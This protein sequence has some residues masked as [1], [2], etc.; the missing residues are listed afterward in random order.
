VHRITLG[1][2]GFS[3]WIFSLRPRGHSFSTDAPA[4][5]LASSLALIP[6][7]SGAASLPEP[8]CKAPQPGEQPAAAGLCR[9]GLGTS[10]ASS[11]ASVSFKPFWVRRRLRV[12]LPKSTQPV[13]MGRDLFG[14]C[15]PGFLQSTNPGLGLSWG[16]REFQQGSLLCRLSSIPYSKPQTHPQKASPS[17]PKFTPKTQASYFPQPTTTFT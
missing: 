11:T 9:T 16:Q 8:A 7:P 10:P 5:A 14:T 4:L 1:L 13:S 15:R 17:H 3:V 2:P 6:A 12:G